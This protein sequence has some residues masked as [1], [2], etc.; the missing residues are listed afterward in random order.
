MKTQI[1]RNKDEGPLFRPISL[2]Y[3]QPSAFTPPSVI[4]SNKQKA[5]SSASCRKIL[6]EIVGHRFSQMQRCAFPLVD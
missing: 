6:H 5:E 1:G 4:F 2:L 3:S